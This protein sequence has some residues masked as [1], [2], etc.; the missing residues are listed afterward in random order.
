MSLKARIVKY[1]RF[2]HVFT[3]E[4]WNLGLVLPFKRQKIS[5]D[6]KIKLTTR[7]SRVLWK[8]AAA[9]AITAGYIYN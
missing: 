2:S 1:V 9:A 6:N 4:P 3:R 5:N 8:A 7:Q